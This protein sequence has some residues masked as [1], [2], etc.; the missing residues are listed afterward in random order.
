M[1]RVVIL[2]L[3][4]APAAALADITGRA[5]IIDGDTLTVA[6]QRIRLAGID[7]PELQQP[8]YDEAGYS[9]TCGTAAAKALAAHLGDHPAA[10]EPT[11]TDRYQRIVATCYLGIEDIGG[12]LVLNGWA[13]DWPR[14]SDG[15]YSAAQ[16]EAKA[17]RRGIW[18]GEFTVP[19][20]WRQGH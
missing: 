8:C 16:A 2:A 18:R 11:G 3:V 19:W 13:L 15:K 1:M 6:G 9:W 10:C 17:A 12:W 14:Y 7:A 20:Q 4:L 5:S